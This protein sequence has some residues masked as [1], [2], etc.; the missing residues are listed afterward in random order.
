M[1]NEIFAKS[2]IGAD[3]KIISAILFIVAGIF[4]WFLGK[5][6]EKKERYLEPLFGYGESKKTKFYDTFFWIP[7]RFWGIIYII[8]GILFYFFG[9]N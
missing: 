3:N 5:W 2:Q 7:I 9:D 6:R 8:S 4:L 1:I